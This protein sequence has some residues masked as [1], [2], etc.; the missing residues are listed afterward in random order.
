[1]EKHSGVSLTTANSTCV[2]EETGGLRGTSPRGVS[3][4]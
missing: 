4:S 2:R 1:M 3:G